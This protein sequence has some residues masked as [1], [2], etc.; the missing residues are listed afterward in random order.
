MIAVLAPLS[1][2][3]SIVDTVFN[4]PERVAV[5][6]IRSPLDVVAMSSPPETEKSAA[7]L[8][9]R[10]PVAVTCSN[11]AVVALSCSIV[12]LPYSVVASASTEPA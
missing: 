6:D 9:V 4:V 8:K 1:D 2:V 7:E 11:P 12:A 3:I 10:V 5:L